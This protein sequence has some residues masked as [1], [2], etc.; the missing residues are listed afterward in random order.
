MPSLIVIYLAIFKQVSLGSL[1]FY[2]KGNERGR[3]LG[4]GDDGA[5]TWKTVE[6][7]TVL[8]M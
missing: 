1:L 5:G 3:D 6:E 7:G 8:R 2:L 4:I